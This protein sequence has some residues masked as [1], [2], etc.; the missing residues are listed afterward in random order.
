MEVLMVKIHKAL[1]DGKSHY[2]ATRAAWKVGRR[3]EN[4]K[5]VCGVV[6]NKIDCVFEP[7]EWYIV[8]CDNGSSR[9]CFNGVDAPVEIQNKLI[10]QSVKERFGYSE[11]SYAN[12][13]ELLNI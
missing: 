2:D 1:K 13:D 6:S 12:L 10:G 9:R 5:Y 8:Q 11:K 4:V 7:T 3:A